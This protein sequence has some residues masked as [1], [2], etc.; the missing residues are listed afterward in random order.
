MNLSLL[1]E[2]KILNKFYFINMQENKNYIN[3]LEELD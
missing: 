2:I 1:I 3:D